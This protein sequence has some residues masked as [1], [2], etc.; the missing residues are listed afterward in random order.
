MPQPLQQID[1]VLAD[2]ERA[3]VRGRFGARVAAAEAVEIHALGRLESLARL[4]GDAAT[5]ALP[6]ARAEAVLA[7]LQASQARS[8]G[9][10]RARVQAGRYTPAG[11]LRALSRHGGA[12]G[13]PGAFDGMDLLLQGLLLHREPAEP[14][15]ALVADMVP[16]QPTPARAILD[17]VRQAAVGPE[18]F[19][20][21]LGSG[22]GLVAMLT[23]LLSGARARG[24]ELEPAYVDYARACAT[25]LNLTGVD[26]IQADARVAPLDHGTVYY[27]FTPF[28]GLILERVLGRLRLEAA[29][30]PIKIGAYGPCVEMVSKQAWLRPAGAPAAA[31]A[32]AVF[33][34]R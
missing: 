34:S 5:L 30:R 8:L 21:D 15:L 6:R 1:Q 31:P 25:S 3:S 10:L 13:A 11:L 2:A 19:L 33:L 12:A 24:I 23:A 14:R 4:G 9:R 32:V 22:L 28:R 27:L 17:L 26:F 29:R 20:I 16:Y 7:R 18:D